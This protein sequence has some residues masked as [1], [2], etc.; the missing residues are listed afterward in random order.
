MSFA[1]L[2]LGPSVKVKSKAEARQAR[3]LSALLLGREVALVA[4]WIFL[5]MADVH[6]MDPASQALTTGLLLNLAAYLL[7]RTPAYR[8]GAYLVIAETFISV[9]IVVYRTPLTQVLMAAPYW[10]ALAPMIAAAV[11]DIRATLVVTILG[12]LSFVAMCTFV[13]PM[14]MA[15]LGAAFVYYSIAALLA[16][17]GSAMGREN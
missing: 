3:F 17:A 2:A 8:W 4:V 10:L 12:A 11:L 16:G 13:D 9:P 14:Q 1:R 15:G 6:D 7:S 5:Q